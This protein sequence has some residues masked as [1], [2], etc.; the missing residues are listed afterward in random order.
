MT[1][2][3]HSIADERRKLIERHGPWTDHNIRLT[4]EIYTLEKT[5]TSEK[6]NRIVQLVA[7]LAGRPLSELRILDL[8]CLEGQYAIEFAM[9][10]AECVAIEG[11]EANIEK[12]RFSKRVLGLDRLT[13]Y[14]DDVRNLSRERYGEFDVVLCLG[15]LYHLDAPDVFAFVEKIAE[16][17]RKVAVF[18]TFFSMGE[19]REYS[20][21]GRT[22]WGRRM[23]EHDVESDAG[24]RLADKWASLDN[25]ASVWITRSTLLNLLIQS[26][27]TSAYECHAPVE[28]KKP[29]DRVTIAGVKGARQRI[30]SI[31]E[32]NGQ[33]VAMIQE[34]F[35]PPVSPRQQDG[36]EMKKRLS[37]MVPR[38]IRRLVKSMLGSGGK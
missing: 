6:L 23:I 12:V 17:T 14:Q 32:M 31:P 29:I 7:D 5:R 26:G 2:D 3:A 33:P 27:F 38:R 4:D 1:M 25:P 30:L 8:A 24:E 22:Y 35:H 10:G 13:V 9:H 21:N 16:V 11:R 18:D 34:P 28:M 15:I 20:Y 37:H 36:V 19:E